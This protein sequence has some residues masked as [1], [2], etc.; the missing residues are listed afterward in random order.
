MCVTYGQRYTTTYES[1]GFVTEKLA[2]V[3]DSDGL[4]MRLFQSRMT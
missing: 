4:G 3:S 1:G 2:S